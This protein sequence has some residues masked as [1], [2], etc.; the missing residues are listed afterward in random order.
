MSKP[1][2]P[3][4]CFPITL[5]R[6]NRLGRYKVDDLLL[7]EEAYNLTCNGRCV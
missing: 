7:R 3:P 5:T 6:I 1:D 2:P 4:V